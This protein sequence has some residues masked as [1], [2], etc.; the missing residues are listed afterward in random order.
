[1]YIY[2][3]NLKAAPTLAMWRLKDMTVGGLLAVLGVILWMQFGIVLLAALSALYLFL[4]IRFEDAC[5]LDFIRKAGVY[6]LFQAQL[7]HWAS[8]GE[9]CSEERKAPENS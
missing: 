9:S 6:F 5:I 8:G 3:D 4:T 2:P 7:Y 1:M